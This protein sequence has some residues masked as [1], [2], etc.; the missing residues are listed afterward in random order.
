MYLVVLAILGQPAVI[1]LILLALILGLP[2]VLIVMTSRKVVYVCWM[3]VYLFSLPIWNFVLPVYAYWHFDDF[4]WGETRK[5]QG[6]SKGQQHGDK[7]G[8]FDSSKI[9]M[10]KWCEFER[11]RRHRLSYTRP[12][13]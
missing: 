5:V 12:P 6:E 3:L 2:A 13:L 10:K 7:D 1:S 11:D 4:T 9:V 8:V